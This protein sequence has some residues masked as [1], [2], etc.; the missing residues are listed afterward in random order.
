[1]KS[2]GEKFRAAVDSEKP[3]QVI[4]T[5]NALAAK[6]AEASGF[7]ALYL[8]G[9]GVAA[10]SL[11]MPDLGISTMEDVLIDVRRITEAT[12]FRCW[13]ISTPAG[14]APSTSRGRF[15]RWKKPARPRCTLKI[16]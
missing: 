10:N 14:A 13:L 2:A 7:Q 1:M 11:G 8:S 15:A 9:G 5:I 4:G 16:R 3:L 12:T 6:M